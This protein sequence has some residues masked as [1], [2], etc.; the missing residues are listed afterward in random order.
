MQAPRDLYPF[1]ARFRFFLVGLI[2]LNLVFLG[3]AAIEMMDAWNRGWEASLAQPL[4]AV[5]GLYLLG[6]IGFLICSVA[7][8]WFW[9]RLVEAALQNADRFTAG[10]VPL[11]A[12]LAA[13]SHLVPVLWFWMPRQALDMAYKSAQGGR[14]WQSVEGHA[15]SRRWW[16]AW[17]VS[18]VLGTFNALESGW[19]SF[20]TPSF[21]FGWTADQIN[22]WYT[23]SQGVYVFCTALGSLSAVFLFRYLTLVQ[24]AH[25]EAMARFDV[26]QVF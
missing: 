10:E 3:T 17:I 26:D 24:D 12:N 16:S 15:S 1:V 7:A 21:F 5:D 23:V 22:A 4:F 13:W 19:V 2:A 8:A 18:G 14:A 20:R 11:P 6:A 9:G 25:V